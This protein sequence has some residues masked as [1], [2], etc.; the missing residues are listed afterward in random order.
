MFSLPIFVGLD[1]H[2]N[3][4]QVCVM[5]QNRISGYPVHSSKFKSKF[6]QVVYYQAFRALQRVFQVVS[7]NRL[8]NSLIFIELW[9]LFCICVE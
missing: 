9:Q 1:Y 8:H 6:S 3:V 2:Q 4:I 7:H 5:D